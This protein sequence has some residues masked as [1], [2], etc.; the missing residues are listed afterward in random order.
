MTATV[1]DAHVD[2]SAAGRAGL[3]HR[4]ADVVAVLDAVRQ[5]L[6]GALDTP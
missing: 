5:D 4:L 3:A 2:H 6:A 1:M